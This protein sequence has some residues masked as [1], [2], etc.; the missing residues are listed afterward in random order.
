M[1]LDD[2]IAQ[3][4]KKIVTDGYE[5]SIGEIMSLYRNKEIFVDPDYQRLFRWTSSQKT[6]F[7]ES[8]LLGIPIPPIF[9][10][11]RGDGTWELI[12]GLQ[13]L[14]TV[15]ELAGILRNSEGNTEPASALEA[16]E[17][18][19]SLAGKHWASEGAEDP[20]ALPINQQLH[21]KRARIRIEILK[22]DSDSDAKFELFQRLNT[23]GS[24]LSEQEVRNCVLVMVNRD[25]YKWLQ[26]L[27]TVG[28]FT[29]TFPVSETAQR[30]QRP[31]EMALRFVAYRRVPYDRSLDVNEYLDRAARTLA[32]MTEPEKQAEEDIFNWTFSLL[33]DCLDENAFKRWDGSRH[34]GAPLL[35]GFE[36]IAIGVAHNRAAIEALEATK[37]RAFIE[38]RTRSIW[39][40]GTFKS[41]SGMGVRGTTRLVNLLPLGVQHFRP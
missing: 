3:A 5:M 20:D 34:S 27:S 29:K 28:A 36:A 23:G 17:L 31:I 9:V 37:R 35:S 8:L 32:R 26:G 6:R 21:I 24:S 19:P 41:N 11:Q 12:D 14:S 10:Y 1:S 33:A 15:L 4:R 30:E 38:E 18:L 16:T 7:I 25:F 22:S 39:S 40:D 2:E 13:R